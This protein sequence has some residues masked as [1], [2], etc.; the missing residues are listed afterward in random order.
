MKHLEHL[1]TNI[2]EIEG[3]EGLFVMDPKGATIAAMMPSYYDGVDWNILRRRVHSIIQT[4][5]EAAFEA[6]ET[7]LEYGDKILQLS[8]SNTCTVGVVAELSANLKGMQIATRLFM[9]K[10]RTQ[11]IVEMEQ[12]AMPDS[13]EDGVQTRLIS[14]MSKPENAQPKKPKTRPPFGVP[15]GK[16]EPAP[17]P[18]PAKAEKPEKQ[19]DKKDKYKGIWG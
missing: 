2:V 16:E 15:A 18:A 10:V 17:A 9:K 6:S 3:V 13:T 7:L 5:D 4:F 11:D 1:A 8:R 14:G 19:T 12:A